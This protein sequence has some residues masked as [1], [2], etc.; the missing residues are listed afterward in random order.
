MSGPRCLLEM[1]EVVRK[2][3]I[4]FLHLGQKPGLLVAGHKEIYFALFLVPQAPRPSRTI[5][6]YHLEK[7]VTKLNNHLERYALRT[8]TAATG[9]AECR[10]PG[11]M[12]LS[13]ALSSVI[14]ALEALAFYC[15]FGIIDS[16][17][18]TMISIPTEFPILPK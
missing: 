3:V 4:R 18:R 12:P 16:A 1:Q 10:W 7:F 9:S 6:N 14:G 8:R 13:F 5:L 17:R 2:G 11:H 15:G